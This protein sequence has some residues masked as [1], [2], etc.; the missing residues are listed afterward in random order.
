MVY[1]TKCG[2]QIP[3]D[4][5]FCPKCGTKTLQGKS[6][7][8]AYPADELR[9]AFYQVGVELERAFTIAAHET[10]QAIQNARSNWEKSKP[11]PPQTITCPKCATKNAAGSVFCSSCGTKLASE[12]SHG[13]A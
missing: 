1:C 3:D 5:Y 13:S 12:E 7:K 8:V 10:H 2:A 6:A 4:A 9:D 11:T